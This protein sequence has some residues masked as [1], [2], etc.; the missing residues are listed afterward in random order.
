MML[1]FYLKKLVHLN[2][3]IPMTH[4]GKFDHFIMD[5]GYLLL[6]SSYHDTILTLISMVLFSSKSALVSRGASS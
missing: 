1:H 3:T 4:L 6:Q 5:F 2:P